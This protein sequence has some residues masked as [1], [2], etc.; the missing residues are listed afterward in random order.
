MLGKLHDFLQ[1]RRQGI[2][3]V[4]SVVALLAS[5]LLFYEP[6]YPEGTY[7]WPGLACGHGVWI[8]GDGKI[9]ERCVGDN[10]PKEI[11]AYTKSGNKWIIGKGDGLL[12]PSVFGITIYGSSFK[13][14]HEF[15]FR[16]QL[17]WV[18]YC[19]DWFQLHF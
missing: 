17:S 16:D 10:D 4:S 13:N 12:K 18:I 11:G 3:I 15:Y 6:P 2:L 19:E 9:Y 14:G 8:F 5:F 7:Y 1:R